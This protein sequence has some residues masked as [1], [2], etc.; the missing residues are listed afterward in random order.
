M[1]HASTPET[2]IG[3]EKTT[4]VTNVGTDCAQAYSADERKREKEDEDQMSTLQMRQM[5]HEYR[6]AIEHIRYLADKR[7][8]LF[9]RFLYRQEEWRATA[10]EF[11]GK[12]RFPQRPAMHHIH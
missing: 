1:I 8:W 3:K 5:L 9:R 12:M 10:Q 11:D 4:T 2:R 7:P 6:D